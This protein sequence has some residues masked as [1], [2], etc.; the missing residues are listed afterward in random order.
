MIIIIRKRRRVH[1][2]ED[3]F[4]ASRSR[5]WWCVFRYLSCC[6]SFFFGGTIDTCSCSQCS[7]YQKSIR[8]R[9]TDR[10]WGRRPNQCKRDWQERRIRHDTRNMQNFSSDN[11]QERKKCSSSFLTTTDSREPPKN[12]HYHHQGLRM[13]CLRTKRRGSF[14]NFF[15]FRLKE[16]IS[17][18]LLHSYNLSLSLS[19]TWIW[20]QM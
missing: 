16:G 1:E 8:W 19:W 2:T 17:L 9:E 12:N 15:R 14:M 3:K 18:S 20:A 6:F 5:A 11:G 10:L 13:E 7:W 4:W